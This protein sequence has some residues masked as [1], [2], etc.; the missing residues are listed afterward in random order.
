[1]RRGVLLFSST[2]LVAGTVAA[3]AAVAG[4][5]AVGAV[6]VSTVVSA[7]PRHPV[8]LIYDGFVRNADGSLTLA[9]GYHNVNRV[10]V[11][12][13]GEDNAFLPG[14]A[15][16]GQPTVFL[17]GRQRFACVMVVPEAFDGRLQWQVRFAGHESVTTARV[18]DPLYALEEASAEQ[19]VEGIV[20][21]GAPQGICLERDA[22]SERR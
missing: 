16:R 18:L 12:V 9:F 21:D 17:P 4:A 5:M 11:T 20:V 15:D 6:T 13:E 3:V 19:A 1:M 8:Y 10:E 7:Q 14:A 2:A 22:A